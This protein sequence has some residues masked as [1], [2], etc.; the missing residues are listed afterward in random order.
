MI[1]KGGSLRTLVLSAILALA[2]SLA[3]A[4]PAF[5]QRAYIAPQTSRTSVGIAY[6][7][8]QTA[9]N[10]NV[11]V[12][13]WNDTA[14]TPTSVVDSAGNAYLVA[15]PTFRGSGLSQ[16]I[17]YAANIK[18]AAAGTNT[19]TVSFNQAAVFIDLR[20]AEYSGL[21]T[22]SPFDV[23]RSAAGNAATA[24]SGTAAT[25]AASELLVG[26]GTTTGGFS[27]A[28]SN[29][30]NRVITIPDLDI[31][32]DRIVTTTGSFAAFAPVNG[33]W[34][35]QI[36]TFK[37]P[38]AGG[39][40]A[41]PPTVSFGPPA[42]GATLAATATLNATA[43]DNVAVA[44]VQFL[45]DGASLGAEAT[46][47]PYSVSWNTAT[48]A[49]GA[50]TVAARARDAAG[51]TATSTPVSVTVDN[52]APSGSVVIAGGA[53]AIN[54][55]N[56]TLNLSANDLLSPVTQMRFSND[57]TSFNAAVAY[58]T[59][60]SWTLTSGAGTKT[61]FAQFTD[62]AG[63]TSTSVSDTI[64]YDPTPPAISAVG[65]SNLTPS[66]AT[67][68]WT[69]SEP[70]TSQADF[71]LTASYGTT[72]T[73]DP[74]LVTAH[75]L[76]LVGLTQGTTYNFR[77]RSRDAANNESVGANATFTTASGDSTPPTV[78]LTAPAAGS[79]VFGNRRR[80]GERDR[81]RR[82][83]SASSSRSTAPTSAPKTPR[84]RTRRPG[85][86]RGRRTA[87][88]PCPRARATRRGTPPPPPPRSPSPTRRRRTAPR[89]RIRSTRARAPWPRM[90]RGTQTPPSST[91][92]PAGLRAD[93]TPPS[94]ST[95]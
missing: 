81:H 21:A 32:E 13:G 29:F 55:L 25:T 74:T 18:S 89:P 31:L 27:A 44:G 10:L 69:T 17:Y 82:A 6:A 41:T 22:T 16:A 45:L 12:V 37:A 70:A 63:N 80:Y 34:V 56:V 54:S 57:G 62:A 15:V 8:A 93:S 48:A 73:L 35:M 86:A 53:A 36:A 60:A 39:G 4:A 94:A 68:T 42:N 65:A 30:T 52:Q 95:E 11:V 38:A 75:T 88:T 84:R 83:S 90:L 24:S 67:I 51:N 40:D 23:G 46:S 20:V 64:V 85:T 79:T 14:A 66:S 26:G 7:A 28:G 92:A 77:V 3:W 76:T 2:P 78:S 33:D 72:T 71:G 91:T 43:S 58:A 59:T 19:V 9:G 49:N 5:V 87:R 47:S 1:D 50:H 61:V